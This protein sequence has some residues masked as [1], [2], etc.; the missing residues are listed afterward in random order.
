MLIQGLRRWCGQSLVNRAGGSGPGRRGPVGLRPSGWPPRDQGLG[1]LDPYLPPEQG[2]G[3]HHRQRQRSN[4]GR[5]RGRRDRRGAG[6]RKIASGATEQLAQDLLPRIPI[7]EHAT[8]GL[9]LGRDEASQRLPDRR[10][11]RSAVQGEDAQGRHH[12]CDDHERRRLHRRHG[13]SGHRADDQRRHHGH[14][15]RRRHRGPF[16]ERRCPGP[17]RLDR[18]PASR[19]ENR[20]WRHPRGAAGN[21][22]SHRQGDLGQRRHQPDRACRSR[23]RSRPNAASRAG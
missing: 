17:V 20:Q 4:R 19:A 12:P 5:R 10:Q 23:F 1:D 13:G 6:R 9:R 8:A 2:R 18:N 21:G 16:R 15:D 22:E 14:A 7:E 11:L 3:G